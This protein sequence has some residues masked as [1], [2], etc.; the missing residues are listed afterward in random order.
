MLRS[1]TRQQRLALIAGAAIIAGI[2]L[3]AVLLLFT[4]EPP[5]PLAWPDI[6]APCEANAALAFRQ[7]GVAASVSITREA[8]LVTINGPSDQAWDVFSATTRLGKMGCGPY[9][10]I[11]VDVPDPEG[12]PDV[13]L[14]YELTGPELQMWAAGQLND[15]Q[16]AERMRRQMYQTVP[17]ATPTP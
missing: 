3:A 13:R 16:L 15:A 11:R 1:L 17:F 4:G 5:Q 2:F 8:L 14:F 7:Q 12:R 6:G 9:N 10:L